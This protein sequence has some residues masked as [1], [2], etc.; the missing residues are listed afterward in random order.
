MSG[1]GNDFVVVD[2]RSEAAGELETPEVVQA[3]CARGTGVGADGIVFLE[4]SR[5]GSYRIRYL[6]A[7]GSLAAL[8]GNATLCSAR[9]AVELGAA[10]RTGFLIE[11][12]AGVLPARFVDGGGPEIDLDPVREVV[13]DDGR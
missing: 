1:S 8:C 4:P 11:T 3:V 5:V 9:L 10:D 13:P 12:D 7:D 2:A 6:N